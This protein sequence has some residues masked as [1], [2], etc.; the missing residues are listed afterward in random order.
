MLQGKIDATLVSPDNLFEAEQKSLKLSVLSD[1]NDLGIYTSASDLSAKRDFLKNQRQRARAFMMAYCEAIW[2][3]KDQQKRRA[4]EFSQTH[5]GEGSA[6]AGNAAQKL[7]GRR[8]AAQTLSDGRSHSSRDGKSHPDR[9]GVSWQQG[10]RLRRQVSARAS[11]KAKGSSSRLA[12]STANNT[13]SAISNSLEGQ[14]YVVAR[15]SI[16]V[17]ERDT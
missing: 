11:W 16:G 13:R 10:R 8:A 2:L 4:G 14:P 5:A 6:P 9:A 3:G 15:F 1:L 12:A 7:R 17:A